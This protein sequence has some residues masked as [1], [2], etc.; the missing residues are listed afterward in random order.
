MFHLSITNEINVRILHPGDTEELFQLLERNRDRLRPWIHPSALPLTPEAT[1]IYTTECAFGQLH[2]PLYELSQFEVDDEKWSFVPASLPMEMGVWVADRLAG[3][4]T[5]FR[6]NGYGSTAE[7]G[8]WIGTEWEGKGI[9][10]RCVCALMDYAI[11]DL[12]IDRFVIGC[13]VNNL[14]SR[15]IPERLGYRLIETVPQGE[16]VGDYVYDRVIYEIQSADWRERTRTM[17][18][19]G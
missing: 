7:V 19:L 4:I 14:R 6:P 12:G 16:V 8:Y 3:V 10:T 17:V 18:Q 15:A 13:A 11:A 9:I 2:N 1:R 5:L